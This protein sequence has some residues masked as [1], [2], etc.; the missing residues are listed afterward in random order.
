MEYQHAFSLEELQEQQRKFANRYNNGIQVTEN[1]G[2]HRIGAVE[3]REAVSR[4]E[5]MQTV[6]KS[7]PLPRTL[8]YQNPAMA[9][10]ARRLFAQILC[11]IEDN[12]SASRNIE[13]R[14]TWTAEQAEVI[15]ALIKHAVNDPSGPIPINK[16][17][18]LWGDTLK[19]KTTLSKALQALHVN[20]TMLRQRSSPKDF[21]FSDV[22]RMYA[23]FESE[24]RPKIEP[25]YNFD[26]LFDDVGT[27]AEQRGLR[28]FGQERDPMAEILWQRYRSW[29][30]FGR[31]TYF[32][33]NLPFETIR[34]QSCG[35]V[36]G[37][38]N[39]FDERLQGRLRE[40]IH[41]ILFPS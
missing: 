29:Q 16:G 32:T 5:V 22:P 25:F 26:R 18:Y 2:P 1:A 41:P 35:A 9:I 31:L 33:S 6:V 37:W 39:R 30:E 11:L 14:F 19:G 7:R 23:D 13:F 21:K 12:I 40:M 38:V 28:V 24:E 20:I 34:T 8:V 17:W 36:I 27:D 4:F 10:D 3:L 15:R